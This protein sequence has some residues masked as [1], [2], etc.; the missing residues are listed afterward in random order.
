MSPQLRRLFPYFA[1]ALI[2][3]SLAWAIT[4]GTLPPADFTFINGTEIKSVD[5]AKVT[6]AP[7]GRI[8]NGI[9]EGLY[10][11]LPDKDDPTKMTPVPAIAESYTLS[12]DRRTYT[13]KLRD[14]AAWTDGKTAL[15][16]VTAEDFVWSW[17]R[18]L[19]PAM[20]SEYSYQLYYVTGAK[21]YSTPTVVVGDRVEVELD[22]RP[23]PT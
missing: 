16:P 7:E 20:A 9:F 10:R 6:G 13:F 22:D 8:I 17:R 14:S 19:H 4:F 12:K 15:R 5:P 2:G 18:F 3:G 21:A 11:S 23:D 1:I